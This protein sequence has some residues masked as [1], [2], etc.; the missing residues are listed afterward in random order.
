MA[1]LRVMLT[2]N[3]PDVPAS[4]YTLPSIYNKKPSP[5]LGALTSF[6]FFSIQESPKGIKSRWSR[7]PE[8]KTQCSGEARIK[9]GLQGPHAEIE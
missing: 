6:F 1:Y 5:Y 8:L 4:G 3:S 9:D 2:L 7:F